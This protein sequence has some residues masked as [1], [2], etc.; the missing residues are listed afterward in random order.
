VT[1][2]KTRSKRS[3][4]RRHSGPFLFRLSIKYLFW[5][6]YQPKAGSM[7][8]KE[9]ALTISLCHQLDVLFK[10]KSGIMKK[11]ALRLIIVCAVLS[12]AQSC[13][14]SFSAPQGAIRQAAR[15]L[16]ISPKITDTDLEPEPPAQPAMEARVHRSNSE[17]T[18]FSPE[19]R[20]Q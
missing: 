10:C 8:C 5:S 11:I 14:S 19:H 16:S 1:P 7:Y 12:T 2:L 20:T 18:T 9:P 17:N 15:I 13:G 4:Y 6:K 3:F